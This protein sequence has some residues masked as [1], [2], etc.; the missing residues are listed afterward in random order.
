[1]EIIYYLNELFMIIKLTQ[2]LTDLVSTASVRYCFW[3]NKHRY[4]II[5]NVTDAFLLLYKG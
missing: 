5:K 3:V 1:M 4:R 2:Y